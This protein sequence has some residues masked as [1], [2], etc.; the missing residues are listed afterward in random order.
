MPNAAW[1]ETG[2]KLLDEP[3]ED[4]ENGGRRSAQQRIEKES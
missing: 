3:L 2:I 1:F 4:K